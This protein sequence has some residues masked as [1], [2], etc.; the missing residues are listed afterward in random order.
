MSK[1]RYEQHGGSKTK[2]YRV[3][4]AMKERCYDPKNKRFSSYGGKGVIVCDRWLNSFDDFR[5]DVSPGYKQG[6]SLDRINS[7]G[8]YEPENFRWAT[9]LEQANNMTTN[10]IIDT[11][12][13]KLNIKQASIKANISPSLLKYRLDKGWAYEKLFIAPLPNYSNSHKIRNNKTQTL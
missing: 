4:N 6:L 9:A 10:R 7:N 8:N 11:P 1:Q 2:L 3:W 13:G 5:T 12:W